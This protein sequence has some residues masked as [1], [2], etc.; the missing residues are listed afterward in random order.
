MINPRSYEQII[1]MLLSGIAVSVGRSGHAIPYVQVVWR[2]GSLHAKY[3]DSYNVHR[4]DSVRMIN[5]AVGGAYG[6]ATTTVP[7]DWTRPAGNDMKG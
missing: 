7:D 6:I 2:N 5:S 4:Y 1:C 3:A